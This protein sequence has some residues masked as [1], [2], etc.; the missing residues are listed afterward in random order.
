[1]AK[2]TELERGSELG[3][4]LR[5]SDSN[6]ERLRQEIGRLA[7]SGVLLCTGPSSDK[8][9]SG[10]EEPGTKK[11][12]TDVV[13]R[14]WRQLGFSQSPDADSTRNPVEG[15]AGQECGFQKPPATVLGSA[16]GAGQPESPALQ[17]LTNQAGEP[18]QSSHQ[19]AMRS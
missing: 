1:M 14:K 12:G 3:S 2:V 4:K 10:E 6:P 7:P 15:Q 17:G 18:W 13:D 9:L 8:E 19:G 11:I 16:Q 5:P